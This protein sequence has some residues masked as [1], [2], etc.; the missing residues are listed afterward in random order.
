MSEE[1]V[2]SYANEEHRRRLGGRADARAGRGRVWGQRVGQRPKRGGT[3]TSQSGATTATGAATGHSFSMQIGS[4][5]A[6]VDRLSTLSG[7][8][9]SHQVSAG[10]KQ[11]RQGLAKARGRLATTTFPASVQM[12]KQELMG[13]L[14]QWGADL[15][16][17]ESSADH[18]ETAQALRQAKSASYRDL[19]SLI[20]TIQSTSGG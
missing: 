8:T 6:L 7:S 15:R 19:T 2:C 10:L 12:Q 14:D 3:V 11:I 20:S 4:L 9:G 13:F 17:A 5:S 18:G 1:G 16:T